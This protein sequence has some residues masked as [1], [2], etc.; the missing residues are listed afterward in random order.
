MYK[1]RG[2]NG[3]RFFSYCKIF[4]VFHKSI[5]AP[6]P[7]VPITIQLVPVESS[8]NKNKMTLRKEMSETWSVWA[9]FP[10]Q[11]YLH[12]AFPIT[13][14]LDIPYKSLA[15]RQK[16]TSFLNASPANKA[17]KKLTI[18]VPRSTY[19]RS[20]DMSCKIS[21]ARGEND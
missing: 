12:T 16:A 6:T 20:G 9:V 15:P 18:Y 1:K 8:R 19:M 21:I 17:C 11:S 3:H 14:R 4:V 7:D 2:E 5:T 13:E 10:P